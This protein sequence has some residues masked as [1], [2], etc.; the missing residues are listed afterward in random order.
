[1]VS[2]ALAATGGWRQLHQHTR[3]VL[4]A[5]L[6]LNLIFFLIFLYAPMNAQS[7]GSAAVVLI[8]TGLMIPVGSIIVYWGAR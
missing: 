2:V 7:V 4:S 3:W 5:L 8:A 6:I 1:V